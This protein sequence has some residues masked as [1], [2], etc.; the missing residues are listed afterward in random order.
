MS[1]A[2]RFQRGATQLRV[3]PLDFF[4]ALP[5]AS[6]LAAA[7][8]QRTLLPPRSILRGP[9]TLGFRLGFCYPQRKLLKM[10][11]CTHAQT[12]E[13]REATCLYKQ[14]KRPWGQSVP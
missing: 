7:L 12:E 4:C 2:G 10:P 6:L 9:E 3:T 13:A 1:F 11:H 8:P 5:A 14:R